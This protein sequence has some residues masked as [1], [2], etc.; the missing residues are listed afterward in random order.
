M[1]SDL[2]WRPL[3]RTDIPAIAALLAAAEQVDVTREIYNHFDLAVEFAEDGLDLA[4]DTVGVLDGTRLVGM[5]VVR[6]RGLVRGTY[7]TDLWGTV[8]PERRGAG[9]G[10][11]IL[12]TQLHRAAAMHAEAEPVADTRVVV[13]PFDHCKRHVELVQAAGLTP[14]RHWFDMER[15]LTLPLPPVLDL[16]AGLTVVGYDRDR[17]D[18]VRRAYNGSFAD[19][20][21]ATDQDPE[22]WAHLFTGSRAFRPELSCLVLDDDR[23][24]AFC[25]SYFYE[26]DAVVDGVSEAW[27][28][29]VGTLAGYRRRGIGG[30]LIA[31]ALHAHRADGFDRTVLDVDGE[32]D[33]G[34]LGIYARLG[35]QVVRKRTSFVRL[36][37]RRD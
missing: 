36:L 25:L 23:V 14:S 11:G 6:S 4:R 32:S 5:G 27:I 8:H 33:I 19:S 2:E 34:G 13:R 12:A 24:V 9:I 22:N 37:P 29:Q 28:G 31:R 1:N 30:H 3:S 16:P 35:F 17:D 26:A 15:E 7:V 10:R 21:G 18:E 20:F